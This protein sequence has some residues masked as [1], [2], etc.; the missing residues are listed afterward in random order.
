MALGAQRGDVLRLVLGQGMKL[1]G[2]GLGLGLMG[3]LLL[4][5]LMAALLFE[6]STTDP[7]TFA[8]VAL[9]LIAVA[10]LSCWI[11]ARRATK[12]DPVVALRCE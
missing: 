2:I 7:P 10:L 11:P 9:L 12:V 5:R 3:A 6:V 1:I 4:T 8:F